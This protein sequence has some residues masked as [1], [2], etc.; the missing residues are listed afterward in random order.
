MVAGAGFG[1]STAVLQAVSAS[2]SPWAWCSCDRRMRTPASLAANI[3]AAVDERVPGFA[4]GRSLAGD[5]DELGTLLANEL[6][7]TVSDKLLLVLD[8]VHVL[9]E[10]ESWGVVEALVGDVPPPVHIVL[11][12]R[13]STP[14]SLGRLRMRGEVVEIRQP[15]LVLDLTDARALCERAAP[16]IEEKE[17]EALLHLTEGWP[18][19]FMLAARHRDPAASASA[20]SLE[21][22]FAYLA[23]EVLDGLPAEERRVIEALSILDRVSPELAQA[24]AHDPDAIAVLRRMAAEQLFVSRV[25]A[26]GEWYRYHHLLRALLRE[27]VSQL[28][29]VERR[30][31]HR[32]AAEAWTRLG[33]LPATVRHL[34]D[35]GEFARAVEILE[36]VAEEIALS[37]EGDELAGWLQRI[38][39]DQWGD[40]P[41]LILASAV[42]D[43]GS[44]A[45]EAS[46]A[47]LELAIRE[48]VARGD[49]D[50]AS[51]ALVRLW[52]SMNAAGTA[53]RDRVA[54][55]Q[56]L[57]AMIDPAAR[58]ARLAGV[59]IATGEAWAGRRRQAEVRIAAALGDR[60]G[61]DRALGAFATAARA[62]YLDYPDGS[63]ERAIDT[64]GALRRN[65]ETVGTS[66][67]STLAVFVA[68]FR[69][70]VLNDVGRHEEALAE[71]A[72]A[73][74][75]ARRAG[76]LG[77]ARRT[78]AWL[79]LVALAGLGRFEEVE[80]ELTLPPEPV[81]GVTSTH[82]AY[83]FLAPAAALAASRGDVREIERIAAAA[84]RAIAAQGPE[85][86]Q[87]S[88]LCDIAEA[89]RRG[90][91]GV[92]AE[93]L[94]REALGLAGELEMPWHRARACIQVAALGVF[95][96]HDRA[97]EAVRLSEDGGYVDLWA[98]KA[99]EHAA[100]VLA[101]TA[102]SDPSHD[103]FVARA[104]SACGEE[105]TRA[106]V[107]RILE[108]DPEV[109]RR[110]ASAIG[111]GGL[112]DEGPLSRL[113]SDS[114]PQVRVAARRSRV[115][116]P[117]SSREPLEYRGL[118][119]FRV[120]RAGEVI[121]RAAFGREK[122]RALLASLLCA[123]R[124]VHREELF[125]WLWPDLPP[126]RAVR[127]FH[128][129][130]HSLRRALEPELRRG[131]P[132][133]TVVSAGENYQVVMGDADQFDA[134]VFLAL[135]SPGRDEAPDDRLERLLACEASYAGP[136]FPEWP[137]AEWA[138]ERRRT[139]ESAHVQ[140]TG[141]IGRL[142]VMLGRPREAI[143]RFERL[144]AA[145]P[146][147]E[148][149]RRE[150]MLAYEGAGERAL[151]LREFHACRTVMRREMGVEPS[152]ETQ[153]IYRQLLGPIEPPALAGAAS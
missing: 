131:T 38:P 143:V 141:E 1:K 100:A 91:S 112:P 128:V 120:V 123:G 43:F 92:L 114:D 84:R 4:A 50:R 36:P 132:A 147:R 95:D 70:I 63:P 139:C 136:L 61:S 152:P 87:P 48:L 56:P 150:M 16:S 29:D 67:A 110:F 83:R 101:L 148:E 75:G 12:S 122:A 7:A 106:V 76:L 37:P 17:V 127:A 102:I 125:D 28:P 144:I 34:L 108:A 42:L 103:A 107:G 26:D 134:D 19:G 153:A 151:A 20:S 62:F 146:E 137:Y 52:Q 27:R 98:G 104:L 24:V 58:M 66:D 71:A 81:D 86:D 85:T 145:E 96:A 140:A 111:P 118:G 33:D 41:S 59:M 2:D 77:G 113:R 3:V 6:D 94:L 64:L 116:A 119:G 93:S 46:F 44:G 80:G 90:G 45:L 60:D 73:T 129:T 15:D 68:A 8:D 14:L 9:V 35:A 97:I 149:W 11:I 32:R 99:R 57:L 79:R 13:T 22:L 10:Y 39:R 121:P 23:V 82:Y 126:D 89:A 105:V 109:R 31:L 25:D 53:V 138:G 88:A 54:I 40:R 69:A 65:L 117:V 49:H 21:Q 133:S 51:T 74:E 135:A 55:A 47:S 115:S 124:P 5:G 30:E 78:L 18:A 130:M 72:L 142:L